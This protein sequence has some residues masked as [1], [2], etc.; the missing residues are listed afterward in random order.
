MIGTYVHAHAMDRDAR[1]CH[2]ILAQ[3]R[4]FEVSR[5]GCLD[6]LQP[7]SIVLLLKG[8]QQASERLVLG[9][10]LAIGHTCWTH[11]ALKMWQPRSI[12]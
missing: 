9:A 10:N 1:L 3:Q 11:R 4:L 8:H 6:G 12:P 7:C 2:R 5:N